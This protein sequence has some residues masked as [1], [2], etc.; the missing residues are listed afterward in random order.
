MGRCFRFRLKS[1]QHNLKCRDPKMRHLCFS[2]FSWVAIFFPSYCWKISGVP[3]DFFPGF[4]PFVVIVRRLSQRRW[5]SHN[6]NVGNCNPRPTPQKN[7]LAAYCQ[8]LSPTEFWQERHV[9][10]IDHNII[11]STRRR[12][13]TWWRRWRRE[14]GGRRW[15]DGLLYVR[16]RPWKT[17]R[18]IDI[19]RTGC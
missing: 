1:L 8:P 15:M 6:N 5:N 10:I 18:Y 12:R 9:H 14:R 4:V 16:R 17:K 3:T 7:S 19:L 11:K 2:P 13:R